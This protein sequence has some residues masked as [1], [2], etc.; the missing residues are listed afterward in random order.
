MGSGKWKE[1]K[2]KARKKKGTLDTEI[3]I[4]RNTAF[5]IDCAPQCVAPFQE[6]KR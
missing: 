4:R 2:T 6:Q 3:Q 1:G 5:E